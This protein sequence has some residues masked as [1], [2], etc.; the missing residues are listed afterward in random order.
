MERRDAQYILG[1]N[2]TIFHRNK[3]PGRY[4]RADAIQKYPFADTVGS[5][6]AVLHENPSLPHI[7]D[8]ND[9]CL[10]RALKKVYDEFKIGRS[11]F[12]NSDLLNAFKV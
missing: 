3:S 9:T 7:L 10:M 11:G 8:M 4:S 6:E 12:R 1:N 5:V 2:Q